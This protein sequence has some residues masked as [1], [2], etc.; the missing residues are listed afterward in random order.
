MTRRLHVLLGGALCATAALVSTA[1]VRGASDPAE[2]SRLASRPA[3]AAPANALSAEYRIGPGDVLE[4]LVWND[5]ALSRKDITVRPDGRISV[6]L[7]N[8]VNAA[9]LT[10]AE[11]RDVLMKGFSS[12]RT[13]L[14]VSVMVQAI[15]SL[16]ISIIGQVKTPGRFD[17]Q[18]RLTVLD[19][20]S[21]AGGFTDYA[22]KDR[23]V[24]YRTD[25]NGRVSPIGF[26]YDQVVNQLDVSKNFVLMPGDIIVVP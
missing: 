23:I 21:L 16:K 15:Q 19:A 11:L 2:Q 18:G 17:L 7:L 5:P 22:R 25:A 14:E 26:D 8:D 3:D 20:L 4:I 12:Y 10:P 9:S 6:P 24:V 1:V 13:E